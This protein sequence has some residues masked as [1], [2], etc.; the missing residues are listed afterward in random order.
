M[1]LPE[2]LEVEDKV[3]ICD[4][5]MGTVLYE[6]GV[7]YEHPYAYANLTQPDL[8]K[9]IHQEYV[10]A[11]ARILEANTYGA[12]RIRLAFSELGDRV[13]EINRLGAQLAREA[14]GGKALVAGAIGPVGKPL[15]PVGLVEPDEAKEA[16]KE[17][18]LALLEGGVDLIIIETFSDLDELKLAYDAVKELSDLPI[19]LQKTFIEDGET[20]A[21]GL[22]QRVGDTMLSWGAT[23][24]GANCTVG[25]QRM[26]QIIQSMAQ[27]GRGKICAIPTAGLPQLVAGRIVYNA[28]TEY[29]ARY[30]SR[31]AEAGANIIGGC[32]GTTP[33]H[34]RALVEA[35]KDF[36]PSLRKAESVEVAEVAEVVEVI[37]APKL[38]KAEPSKVQ[39]SQFAQKL[40][41]K[42]IITV[43]LDL[44]RGLD[45]SR[46][47][48]GAKSLKAKGVDC[49][50][51]SDG[52][53]A[54]LRMNP[55][56]A[57]HLIQDQ[58]KIEVMMHFSCRDRNLLAIQADLLGAHALGIK[59]IL[60]I[61]G[62]PA[63]VGDYPESTSV[64]DVDSIGLVHILRRFN[65]G[66]DL[67]G[68]SIINRTS[69]LI[70]IAFNP[71]ADDME[72]EYDRLKRKVDAGAHVVY[73]QPLYDIRL[74]ER[75]RPKIELLGIPLIVGL[76][77]LRSS[78]H[79]EFLHNE[80][81][82]MIVPDEIRRRLALCADDKEAA[83][84][85][86]EISQKL[87]I[88]A[89]PMTGGVYLMPAFGRH[90]DAEKVME[91]I[92]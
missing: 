79:A 12:N 30:G 78:R 48:K 45:M 77:P 16:F 49:I 9:Q 29:F 88:E 15:K 2:L 26:L 70:A 7:P 85:G 27:S 63:Q 22:P 13:N 33:E 66:L 39:L 28:S 64:Y 50:D 6:R 4:G 62:D 75:I 68:N 73:T 21:G 71:A 80:V 32:C 87:L 60:A 76:L 43:E 36:K 72:L 57:A 41:K 67:A 40:G 92:Q 20:L 17:Q 24:I 82:G 42:Y 53:R 69:F 23:L 84:I 59:N 90:Q 18:A 34:I 58:A 3:I 47:L 1:N 14:S 74:L 44:P 37:E 54:R 89:K 8:V 10:E 25:P 5:A 19:I 56:V 55:M 83:K 51:I 52:A 31:L 61:T 46:V 38:E 35:L 86:I 81:P 65:E 91:V 11:G